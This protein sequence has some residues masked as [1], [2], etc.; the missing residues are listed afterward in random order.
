LKDDTIPR[1]ALE[2]LGQRG[3][4][5]WEMRNYDCSGGELTPVRN[6]LLV[7]ALLLE[8]NDKWAENLRGLER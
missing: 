5:F 6:R 7:G 1:A 2:F 4:G 8:Q 3:I